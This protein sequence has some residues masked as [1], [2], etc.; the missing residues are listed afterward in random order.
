MW[1]NNMKERKVRKE[2]DSC[3]SYNYPNLRQYNCCEKKKKKGEKENNKNK[4]QSRV[5]FKPK[6]QTHSPVQYQRTRHLYT[7]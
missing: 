6:K 4:K 5:G 2:G 7:N 3:D 1:K